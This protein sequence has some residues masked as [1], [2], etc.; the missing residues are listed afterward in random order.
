MVD[1]RAR[2]RGL[3]G[4]GPGSLAELGG[5]VRLVLMEG[6]PSGVGAEELVGLAGLVRPELLAVSGWGGWLG[7]EGRGWLGPDW[8]RGQWVVPLSALC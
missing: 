5:R 6:P 7:G 4:R 3:A 8:D 2:G 1:L